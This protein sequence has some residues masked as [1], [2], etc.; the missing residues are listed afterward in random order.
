MTLQGIPA[1]AQ[2]TREATTE[3][4][5]FRIKAMITLIATA[6]ETL[7]PDDLY[8]LFRALKESKIE[9]IITGTQDEI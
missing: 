4:Y 5:G 8:R 7:P 3:F 1:K 9:K 2:T 6:V